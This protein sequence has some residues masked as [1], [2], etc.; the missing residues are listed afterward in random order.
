MVAVDS[1]MERRQRATL[2]H[3]LGEPWPKDPPAFFISYRRKENQ[4]HARTIW[5][6]LADRYGDK[7]VFMDLSSIDYGEVF[8]DEIDEAIRWCRVM[9]VLIG[10][11]WLDVDP[12]HGTRRIDDPNDWVR[13]EIEGG[14]QREDAH[15]IPVRLD[16]ANI[17]NEAELPDPIKGLAARQAFVITFDDLAAEIDKLLPSIKR[18]MGRRANKQHSASPADHGAK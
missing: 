8:P 9:L 15:V 7:L 17:P 13:R 11:H 10:P 18:A 3:D 2:R 16:G 1:Y 14:L 5:K 6:E 12:I 4:L